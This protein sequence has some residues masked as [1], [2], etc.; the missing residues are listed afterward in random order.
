MWIIEVFL[1]VMSAKSHQMRS[2][3][4]IVIYCGNGNSDSNFHINSGDR[5][6][7]DRVG[8]GT[9]NLML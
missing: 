2:D 6:V 7:L 5:S 3:D 1:V 8:A 9:I 4:R